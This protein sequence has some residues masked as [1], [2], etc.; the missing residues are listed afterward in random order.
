MRLNSTRKLEMQESPRERERE[1][2]KDDF[3]GKGK[4]KIFPFSIY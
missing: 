3:L 2:G 1:K 4:V